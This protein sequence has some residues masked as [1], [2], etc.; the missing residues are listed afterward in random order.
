MGSCPAGVGER[1]AAPGGRRAPA[2]AV[3]PLAAV[4]LLAGLAAAPAAHAWDDEGHRIVA[5]I[6]EHY[7]RPSVLERVQVLLEAD[8][9][10]LT[11]DTSMASEATWADHY[12]D[13]DRGARGARDARDD[14]DDRGG[15]GAAGAGRG[16]GPRYEQTW[17]WHFVDLELARPDLNSACYGRPALPAGTPASEG[18]ARDCIVDKIE[19]FQTELADPRTAAGERLRALQF[20]LHFIGDLHQPLHTADDHDAGGNRVRVIA[21]GRRPGSLHR[22]WDD[23]FVSDLG[24]DAPRIAATLIAQISSGDRAAWTRGS[25]VDWTMESFAVAQ[26]VAYGTLPPPD[27]DGRRHL[28]DDYIQL[29][30]NAVATQLSRAGVRL[31][32]VLNRALR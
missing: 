31:A 11:P 12:R 23:E 28:S 18:P 15:D 14:R 13:S 7:L 20:L 27:R 5:L 9:S 26:G 19:E 30:D 22:Y 24:P 8:H 29:A 2:M 4:L 10:G 6:A 21:A 3:R 1:R 32:L 17:R 16:H 25:V